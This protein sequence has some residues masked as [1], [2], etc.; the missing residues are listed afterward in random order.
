M[1]IC[2]KIH[3]DGKGFRRSGSENVQM[4]KSVRLSANNTKALF[5]NQAL[6]DVQDKKMYV[7][8]I[9]DIKNKKAVRIISNLIYKCKD[10]KI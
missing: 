4:I 2:K 3:N 5:M 7:Q 6:R 9:F 8:D 1:E 10:L